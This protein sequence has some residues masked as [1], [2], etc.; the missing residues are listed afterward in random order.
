MDDREIITYSLKNGDKGA[1]HYDRAVGA[2]TD[3]VEVEGEHLL[4]S[5]LD[6]FLSAHPAAG[7]EAP[8]TRLEYIYDLLTI[9]IL[10]RIYGHSALR[11]PGLSARLLERLSRLREENP[12]WKKGIDRL[13]GPLMSLLI[14]YQIKPASEAIPL[15]VKNLSRLR[16]WLAA[17]GRFAEEV[18]RLQVWQAFFTRRVE[19]S[20]VLDFS[21][22]MAFAQWFDRASLD[23]LGS[24]TAHVETFLSRTQSSYRGREDY[25]FCGRQRVEYHLSMM[26]TEVLNRALREAFL[27]TKK[28]AVLVPPCLRARPDDQCQATPTPLGARCSGCTPGCRVHQ[29]TKLGEKRGFA[30]LMLPDDLRVYSAGSI[31]AQGAD[32]VGIIGVSCALTNAPGGWQAREMNIQAQGVILEYCGCS[33]HWHKQGIPTSVNFNQ[34]LRI[35]E[36]TE[37]KKE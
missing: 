4:G 25:I 8:R 26:G 27:K 17:S 35:F 33:Y 18:K 22:V 29:L 24:Y 10:W 31:P 23:A 3:A 11:F 9:G 34:L 12:V 6:D 7:R 32:S 2:L 28:K 5:L 21:P 19:S 20:P 36:L 13:R 30:V 16:A 14:P 15:S 37:T 1:Y